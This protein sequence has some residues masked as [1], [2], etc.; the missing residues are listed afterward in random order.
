MATL[1]A[2]F[3]HLT[4]PSEQHL[5]HCHQLRFLHTFFGRAFMIM[6]RHTAYIGN[7]SQLVKQ[8]PGCVVKQAN[9]VVPAAPHEKTIHG[10]IL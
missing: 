7:S 3:S 5:M 1:N 2:S 9:T 4:T 8:L 6:A 10:N